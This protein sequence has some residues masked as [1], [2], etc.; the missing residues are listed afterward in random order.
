MRLSINGEQRES[1]AANVFDLWKEFVDGLDI[2]EPRGFAIAL[3]GGV[4][5]KPKWTET[6]LSPGDRVEIVRPMQGG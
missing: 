4:V 3:N 2:D 5:R 1:A 6:R